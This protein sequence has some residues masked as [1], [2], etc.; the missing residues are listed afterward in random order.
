MSSPT[1]HAPRARRPGRT[2]A[3]AAIATVLMTAAFGARA[4]LA[5]A[6][7]GRTYRVLSSR[8]TDT[9][10][11]NSPVTQLQYTSPRANRYVLTRHYAGSK[12]THV[13]W[14]DEHLAG[15][16]RSLLEIDIDTTHRTW[17][18]HERRLPARTPLPL[19]IHSSGRRVRRA[20]AD[21]QA[22]K[23]GLGMKDHQ[24][25]RLLLF[26][27]GVNVEPAD[28]WVNPTTDQPV[29]E[30]RPYTR[31][32]F[33]FIVRSHWERISRRALNRLRAKPTKPTGY[34]VSRP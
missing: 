13:T 3:T 26:D 5:S 23:I 21:G 28:L 31:G 33:N 14:Q 1:T 25:V 17:I 7:G 12:L 16:P 10:P 18:E 4:P 9:N 15:G 29:A 19:G 32:R 24:R 34:S 2:L 6:A 27:D 11:N 20:I 30:T 8:T 22:N